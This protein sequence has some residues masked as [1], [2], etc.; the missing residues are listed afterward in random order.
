MLI[1]TRVYGQIVTLFISVL[2]NTTGIEKGV[3]EAKVAKHSPPET[4]KEGYMRN[5]QWSNKRHIHYENTPIQICWK[6]HLK[7]LK[8]VR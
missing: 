6:I 5:K 1:C 8:I 4:S 2:I 3:R 7:K